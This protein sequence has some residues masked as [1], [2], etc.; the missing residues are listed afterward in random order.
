VVANKIMNAA[1]A[2]ERACRAIIIKACDVMMK[3]YH[4]SLCSLLF[5]LLLFIVILLARETCVSLN[6]I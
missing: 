5:Y 1:R 6:L 3:N 2:R 4:L